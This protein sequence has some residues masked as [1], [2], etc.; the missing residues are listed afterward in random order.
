[1]DA[2][3][4]ARAPRLR[5]PVRGPVAAAWAALVLIAAPAS[6]QGGW[7]GSLTRTTD[8]VLRGLSQTGGD[9]ALQAGANY[10][11][12]S[13]VQ[14]GIWTSNTEKPLGREVDVLL[15]LSRPLGEDWAWNLGF[16][17]YSYP[18]SELPV[19]HDRVEGSAVLA[20][21]DRL[22]LLLAW[23]PDTPTYADQG[24]ER[25]PAAAGDIT[26]QWPLREWLWLAAGLGYRDLQAVGGYRYWN[27][28]LGARYRRFVLELSR[29]G[30]DAS[31]RADFGEEQAGDR[32]VLSLT[33]QFE[34]P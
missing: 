31:A 14:A 2:V 5:R 26:G 16:G 11:F 25:G 19:N 9:P 23:S 30:T 18:D 34:S 32:T 27:V 22:T 17:Y 6:A 8:Y 4:P 3:Q 21:S 29:I 10:G 1:M 15:G 7:Q 24:L 28:G 20:W 13:G 12:T 33:L